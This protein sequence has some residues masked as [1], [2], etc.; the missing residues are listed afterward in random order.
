MKKIHLL[1]KYPVYFEELAKV[2]T[3]CASTDDV[4]SRVCARTSRPL[5]EPP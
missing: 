1:D 2:D 5:R 3:D 4:W